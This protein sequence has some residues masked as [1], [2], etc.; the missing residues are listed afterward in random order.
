M[1]LGLN[2]VVFIQ[3]SFDDLHSFGQRVP[4]ALKNVE[5]SGQLGFMRPQRSLGGGRERKQSRRE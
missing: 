2:I 4:L 3:S 1:V 5:E